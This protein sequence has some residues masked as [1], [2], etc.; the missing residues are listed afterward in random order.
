M[1]FEVI[2]CFNNTW[3]GCMTSDSNSCIEKVNYIL[4]EPPDSPSK[5]FINS[6]LKTSDVSTEIY[7]K[8]NSDYECF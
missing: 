5:S 1:K 2:L 6:V 3:M 8:E 7:S 4:T